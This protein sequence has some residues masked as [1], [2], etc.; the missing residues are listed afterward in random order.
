MY[1]NLIAHIKKFVPITDEEES[2]IIS[3]FRHKKIRKKEFLLKEQ[4]TCTANHFVIKGCFRM[5][6]IQDN[7]VERITQFAIE[8]WWI[9]DYQSLDWKQPSNFNIQAI[10]PSEIAILDR[11]CIPTL[12]DRIPKLDRYFRIIVQRHLAASQQRLF[13]IYSYPGEERYHHFNNNFPGFIQRVPQYMIASYLGFTP[14][15]ISKIKGNPVPTPIRLPGAR[16]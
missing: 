5:Y 10:E 1:E 2:I 3:S 9:T 15:F 4:Q 8:N 11:D 14:E 6:F 13:Y 12:C 7:G 16:P